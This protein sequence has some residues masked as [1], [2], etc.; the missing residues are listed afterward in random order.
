MT[1]TMVYIYMS[2]GLEING[3]QVT[4]GIIC[5][6]NK[7]GLYSGLQCLNLTDIISKLA[8]YLNLQSSFFEFY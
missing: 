5:Y 8:P 4:K 3:N 2:M 6:P 7:F 1:G